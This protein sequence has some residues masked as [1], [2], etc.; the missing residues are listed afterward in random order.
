[1]DQHWPSPP[2]DRFS[3]DRLVTCCTSRGTPL[4]IVY[5]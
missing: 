5:Y 3:T 1:M 4:V 2:P